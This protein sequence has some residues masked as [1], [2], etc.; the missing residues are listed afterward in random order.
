MKLAANSSYGYQIMDWSQDTVTKHLNDETIDGAI[1][2]K[3]FRRLGYI[4]DQLH[5]MEFVK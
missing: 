5:E 4:N 2:N 1:N 3:M